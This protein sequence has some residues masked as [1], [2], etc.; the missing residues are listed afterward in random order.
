MEVVEALFVE[1]VEALFFIHP[2]DWL[3]GI[4]GCSKMI[5]VSPS[6]GLHI[7]VLTLNQQLFIN[8][9]SRKF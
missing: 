9:C 3:P 4:V 2:P 8:P 1:G 6:S 7:F 5:P